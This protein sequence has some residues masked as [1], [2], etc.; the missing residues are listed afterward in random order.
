MFEVLYC[1]T[2]LITIVCIAEL[3]MGGAYTWTHLL[4]HIRH[5]HC[6]S[7]CE[8]AA[9][10]PCVKCCNF[11]HYYYCMYCWTSNDTWTA[12]VSYTLNISWA[13][14]Y[15]KCSD[16]SDMKFKQ[17]LHRAATYHFSYSCISTQTFCF[18][19]GCVTKC[20]ECCYI[21]STSHKNVC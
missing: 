21:G 8:A 14:Q 20:L 19:S 18:L 2:S 3:L 7:T 15:F 9:S 17:Y 6:Q 1:S 16:A 13:I 5:S 4:R 10:T 11:H 12:H